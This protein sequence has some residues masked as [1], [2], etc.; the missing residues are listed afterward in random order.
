MGFFR[1]IIHCAGNGE[2]SLIQIGHE[3]PAL[4]AR[5]DVVACASPRRVHASERV[6]TGARFGNKRR[7]IPDASPDQGHG[8]LGELGDHHLPDRGVGERPAGCGGDDFV[9]E[10]RL[11]PLSKVSDASG[12]IAGRQDRRELSRGNPGGHAVMEKNDGQLR[13]VDGGEYALG[14]DCG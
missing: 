9:I 10:V 3:N 1:L 2:N 13:V 12:R 7:Q 14:A 4:A 6:S 11:P 8:A 5:P